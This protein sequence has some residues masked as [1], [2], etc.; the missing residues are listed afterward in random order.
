MHL[1]LRVPV[2]CAGGQPKRSISLTDSEIHKRAGNPD[3]ARPSWLMPTLEPGINHASRARFAES[4]RELPVCLP[5][6][7]CFLRLFYARHHPAVCCSL[8]R[9]QADFRSEIK[10]R[11]SV[12]LL[13]FR[14]CHGFSFRWVFNA[15]PRTA[16]LSPNQVKRA[17]NGRV[18]DSGFRKKKL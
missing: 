13:P 7:I 2:P 6:S 17:A 9:H 1:P 8:V 4:V 12:S 5:H 10:N 14:H 16:S 15:L 18:T 11:A 3:N